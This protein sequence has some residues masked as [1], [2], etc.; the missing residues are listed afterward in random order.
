MLNALSGC[1]G[2]R[3]SPSSPRKGFSR[4]AGL[5]A[6]IS[7]GLCSLLYL[8]YFSP[9]QSLKIEVQTFLSS[10]LTKPEG[11]GHLQWSNRPRRLIAFGD[12]WSDNGHYPIDPPSADQVAIPDKARGP[13]WTEWLCSEVYDPDQFGSAQVLTGIEMSCAHHDNFARA[14][15]YSWTTGSRESLIDNSILNSTWMN[16]ST[17]GHPSFHP[18]DLGEPIEDLKTQIQ[19]W[20]RFE[21]QQ[22][23]TSRVQEAERKGTVFALWF[24]LWNLWS[25][26]GGDSSNG[27]AAVGKAMDAQFE[28]MDLLADNW[29]M[30]LQIIIPDAI[31]I[32]FLPAWQQMRTGPTGSD[33]HAEDQRNAILL[34]EQWNRAL[35]VRATRWKKGKI[36]IY[37]TNHWFLGQ[38]R[39]EQ[40][41]SQKLV[42]AN[43]LGVN[44]SPWNNVK[45]GCVG[46]SDK[47]HTGSH[48]VEPIRR[49][50]DPTTYL[51][52]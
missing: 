6:V 36:Y 27:Q 2:L 13:V 18:Q 8:I 33:P 15:M 37:N 49:C 52:W 30:E 29:P 21:R 44:P 4:F 34:V 35:D 19:Q 1:V 31:D 38:L 51:F 28:Q 5:T 40:L 20:L 47:S 26:S 22:F 25:Y 39:D 32:T 24:S 46:N 12:S 48:E 50:S 9:R 43:G 41:F 16:V 14:M 45:L 7:T 17:T 23:G 3:Q 10:P 11:K 42:D